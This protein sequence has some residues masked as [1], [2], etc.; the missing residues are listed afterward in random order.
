M[1]LNVLSDSFIYI[2]LVIVGWNIFLAIWGNISTRYP[3]IH[4]HTHFID[5]WKNHITI[6]NSNHVPDPDPK[7]NPNLKSKPNP[8]I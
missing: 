8:K 1:I 7:P 3:H 4:T 2:V 5:R 6:L